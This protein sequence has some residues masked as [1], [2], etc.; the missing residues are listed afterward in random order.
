MEPRMSH[1]WEAASP[2]G[3]ILARL[4]I[5]SRNIKHKCMFWEATNI[6]SKTISI[7][8]GGGPEKGPLGGTLLKQHPCLQMQM[9]RT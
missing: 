7:L 5:E 1:Q 2:K 6:Q 8:K 9:L 3:T 4:D